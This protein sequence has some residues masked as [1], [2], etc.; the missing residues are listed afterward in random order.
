MGGHWWG[1]TKKMRRGVAGQRVDP[2][3]L[4]NPRLVAYARALSPAM[5]RIGGTEA[6]RVRYKP[7]K[8]ALRLLGLVEAPQAVDESPADNQPDETHEF[9]LKK[10]LWKKILD[11]VEDAKLSLL[12]TLSAG[13]ADRDE[14]G[15]WNEENA[16][17]LIAYSASKGNA[18]AA[19]ELGNEVNAF[20]FIYGLRRRVSA[21]QYAR[22]LAKLGHLIRILSPKSKILGPASAVWPRIGELYP[23]IPKLCASP[24]AGFLDAVSWHYYPQ[25]SSHGPVA[26]K[27]AGE[28][29]MLNSRALD[30]ILRWNARVMRALVRASRSRSGL[31][32]TENW[33][34]ETA[35]ALF[36]GEEGLSNTFVSTLWWMDALSLLARE[37]ADKVFRQSLVG[38]RY[39]L[40]DQ[41][42]LDPRPDYYASFIWK[43]LMGEEVL[44]PTLSDAA[45]RKLRVYAHR[46]GGRPETAR[47]G[48]GKKTPT[49]NRTTLLII[50]IDPK[51]TA[52]VGLPDAFSTKAESYLLQGETGLR[53]PTMTLN[54]VR[55]DD[56][57]VLKWN[58]AAMRVKYRVAAMQETGAGGRILLPPA[59]IL[60]LSRIGKEPRE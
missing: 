27:R 37:G 45:D 21:R 2:L 23:I 16:R 31:A 30:G 26:V 1:A 47:D 39:G 48:R 43:H 40:L 38:A 57:L 55:V 52:A 19:W 9:I 10:G 29:T 4:D 17:K 42:T 20:P 28:R 41:E 33:I 60:F 6:D 3:D 25:Q 58:S 44:A 5:L 49:A 32:P 24:A 46:E 35:H 36:G 13:P 18:V 51:R 53:S 59:S 14:K 15:A 56:D 7:G 8:K 12:F 34:T 11:F 22:D 54:G 50:N